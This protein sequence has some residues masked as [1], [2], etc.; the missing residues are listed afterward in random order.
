MDKSKQAVLV[1]N[2]IAQSYSK[3]FQKPSDYIEDFLKLIPKGGKILDVGCGV[4]VDAGYM[5][6]KGF[7]VVGI[8]LSKGMLKIAKKRFPNVDFKLMDLREIRF[9]PNSFDGVIASFSLIHIPKD[10]VLGVLHKIHQILKNG[11]IV[12]IG[13]QKGKS[14]E[15]FIDEPLKPGE[16]LFVNVFSFEEIK[17]L[18]LK[19]GFV[20]IQKHERESMSKAELKFKKLFVIAKKS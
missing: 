9:A 12:Y 2:K 6:S 4:G 11:G 20:I 16:K 5:Y 13:V 19:S 15:V 14:K 18:L 8:D 1:Y 17:E 10:D 7:K 3:K